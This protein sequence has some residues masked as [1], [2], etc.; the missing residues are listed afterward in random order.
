MANQELQEAV[1]VVARGVVDAV[2][3]KVFCREG[4]RMKAEVLANYSFLERTTAE[5][6]FQFKQVIPY[7]VI[8]HGDHFLLMQRTQ[9]Q[10]ETRLHNKYSLGIGGH[11]NDS[12]LAATQL[13][14]ENGDVVNFGMRRELEEEIHLAVE[15][16]CELV[17]VINDD[18]T[19]VA[20]VHMGLVYVLTVAS[21]EFTIVEQDKYTA[22]WK[23][24][25]EVTEYYPDMESWAQIVYDH[26]VITP[27]AAERVKA[28]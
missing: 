25:A 27:A 14:P 12:D 8:R 28:A 21:P 1:L 9:K 19:E 6:D 10:T 26:V 5:H 3:P 17:G 22:V 18:S 20:K 11:I 7:I 15:G 13:D 16:S 24:A 2:C 4:E 23:T